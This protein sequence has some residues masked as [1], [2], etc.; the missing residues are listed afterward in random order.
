MPN[1]PVVYVITVAWPTRID[2]IFLTECKT[3]H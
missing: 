2:T 1:T 3:V